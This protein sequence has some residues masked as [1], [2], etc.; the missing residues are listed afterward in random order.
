M[1]LTRSAY[2]LLKFPR[3][4]TEDYCKHYT[5]ITFHYTELAFLPCLNSCYRSKMGG[6]GYSQSVITRYGDAGSYTFSTVI[7][8]LSPFFRSSEGLNVISFILS[9]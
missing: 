8:T 5:S 9:E 2:D 4:Q 3:W 6:G 1:L 7:F